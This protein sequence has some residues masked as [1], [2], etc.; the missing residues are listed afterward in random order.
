MRLLPALGEKRPRKSR[1]PSSPP[2]QLGVHPRIFEATSPA[3]LFHE[4]IRPVVV[5]D[6]ESSDGDDSTSDHRRRQ[7]PYRAADDAMN[8]RV[9]APEPTPEEREKDI[10]MTIASLI[11]D[12]DAFREAYNDA[13]AEKKSKEDTVRE[14]QAQVRG[15]KSFVSSSSKMDEQISDEALAEMMAT[16]G[17]GLQNWVISN[18]RRARLDVAGL[19][20]DDDAD[21]DQDQIRRQ[22]LRLVPTYETL[23]ASSKI[24][25]LQSIVSNLMVDAIFEP[26]FVGLPE[27][28][29]EALLNAQSCMSIFGTQRH[30]RELEMRSLLTSIGPEE[31]INAWRANTLG[32]IRKDAAETL[33]TETDFIINEV[34]RNANHLLTAI[35]DTMPSEARDQSLRTLLL[36]AVDLA[37]LLRVQRAEFTVMMPVVEDH[38]QTFF[39]ADSMEDIGGE[40]ES[41]L[42]HREILCVVF[43]G[44]MKAGDENGGRGHLRN[45]IGRIRV[46]CSPD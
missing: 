12:R 38:Q 11:L 30:G 46:L 26:F 39:D 32:I 19:D 14:L 13:M 42:A 44:I 16:L 2:C 8:L 25:L 3:F 24:H 4:H 20:D 22:L 40:D 27:D 1:G 34:M 33:T 15:L 28:K 36:T 9:P 5:R 21:D 31:S 6:D 37:R 35:T 18:F 41:T 29:E 23:A 43:P 17:N 10:Q 45:V 7:Q